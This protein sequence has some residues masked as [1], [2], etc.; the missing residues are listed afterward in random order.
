VAETW[1]ET[2][3]D[4]SDAREALQEAWRRAQGE[5]V[6]LACHGGRGRTG[7]ALA[8]LAVLDGVPAGQAVT[9]VREH[10]HAHAVE[11]PWQRRYVGR[12]SPRDERRGAHPSSPPG[13]ICGMATRKVTLSI[14]LTAWALA[15][16]AA[17]RAGI[18]PSAWLSAAARREAVR[19]GAGTDWGDTEAEA[20][21][22]D[23]DLAAA[24]AD[25]R[26]AG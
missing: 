12:F 16:A 3:P 5:R 1:E 13:T 22:Q 26:A 4:R 11:T 9:Y 2:A 15:E 25:L 8:C 23:A 17:A 7:T 24:E 14:D 19:L 6:E 21:A 20:L 10:Y 18:S